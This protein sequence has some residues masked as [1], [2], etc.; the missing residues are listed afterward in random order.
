MAAVTERVGLIATASTTY[1]E[2]YNL[3][4]RFA[5]P[6]HDQRRPRRL[7]RR[8][9]GGR[10]GGRELRP[11]DAAL[12]RRALRAGRGV[13]RGR[14]R[15]SGTAGPTTPCS[16]TR[17]GAC[18]PTPSA[19]GRSATAGHA[20]RGRRRARPCR[21]ARRGGRSSCRRGRPGRASRWPRAHAEA[22][23]TAQ[24]T[25]EDAQEFYRR[26]KN[27]TAEAGRD[28]GL[29]K[30]LPGLVPIL[31]GTEDEA[32]RHERDLDDL[33]VHEHALHQLAGAVGRPGRRPGPRPAAA[34]VRQRGR[35][36]PGPQ[37]PLRAD[38]LAG[39]ARGADRAAAA[40][41][42]RRRPRAPHAGRHAGAGRGLPRA[43]V[44]PGGGRRLQR[45]A[46]RAAVRAGVLRGAR[47]CRSCSSAGCSGRGTPA[48]RSASIGLPVPAA[49]RPRSAG[50]G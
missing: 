4:R 5:T 42:P 2:P 29:L 39:A 22:V 24:Q 11:R 25:L 1:E 14:A 6:R 13:P 48:A 16:P 40:Q 21:A 10:R 26:L 43:V 50:P 28:P 30:V 7:E 37:E 27:A 46:G 31:G 45:D 41:P 9:D 47:A 23:F 32:R 18:T 36:G 12:A 20:L 33:M 8:D 49:G 38:H 15:R 3:A 34:R 17:R 19:S 44:Q 35:R